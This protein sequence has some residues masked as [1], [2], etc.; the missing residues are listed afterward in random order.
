MELYGTYYIGANLSSQVNSNLLE[1]VN[2]LATGV[3]DSGVIQ[4]LR[5]KLAVQEY[6]VS[7][8]H[9]AGELNVV[10]DGLSRLTLDDTPTTDDCWTDIDEDED[11]YIMDI[12]DEN[13]A[14]QHEVNNQ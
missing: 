5:W 3:I 7:V 11:L 9:I 2:P 14:I 10:A 8:A 6:D 13:Q 1:L 12:P 4:L